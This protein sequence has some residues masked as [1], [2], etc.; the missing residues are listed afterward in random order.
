MTRK[1][2]QFGLKT[3]LLCLGASSVL[4]SGCQG[5]QS[6]LDPAGPQSARIGRLWWLM[7]WICSAVYVLVIGALI[8]AVRRGHRR[9]QAD[10]TPEVERTATKAIGAAVAMTVAI[11]FVFLIADFSTGRAITALQSPEGI[12]I[13][14]TGHQWWWDFEYQAQVASQQVRTS[15][16]IHIPTGRP[17]KLTMTSQDV[18]HSFWVPNLHGKTDLLTGYQTVTWIEADRPGLYRGQCAEYCGPQHAHMALAVVAESPE[19][20][21]AWIDNQRRPAPQPATAEQQR[22]EQ[23]F[24]T[25]ACVMC[26]QIRGTTAGGRTAPDLTHLATRQFIAAGTLANNRGNLGGWVVDPQ[27]IK[28]GNKMPPNEL[29]GE[30]LTA[31]LSYLQSLK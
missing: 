30:E 7:F 20:F 15:N 26:H 5:M 2:K 31:L 22:G 14:V 24:L 18:I 3:L 10:Q 23:L 28:P 29:S 27:H 11:L 21:S 25:R 16:E 6:A 19:Q 12:E 9:E 8:Y 1:S 17:V 4:L 13:K